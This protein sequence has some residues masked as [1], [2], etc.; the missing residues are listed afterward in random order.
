MKKGE[1][2]ILDFPVKGGREQT[3]RRP[4]IVVADTKTD[5]VLVIPLTSNLD[6]LE[7][8]DY[9]VK[10]VKSEINK[11]EKDSVGLVFQLQ[12]L[13]KRRFIS[14]IGNLEDD[15]LDEIDN[16]LKDLLKI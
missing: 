2:W 10:I 12:A 1:V 8:F 3:G 6:A 15:C 4:A 11:L 16:V 9:S 7:R 13:D 5:L 14:I